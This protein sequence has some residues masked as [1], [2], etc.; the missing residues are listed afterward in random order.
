MAMT[1]Q[2]CRRAPQGD[3]PSAHATRPTSDVRLL[4]RHGSHS[5]IRARCSAARYAGMSAESRGRR[6]HEVA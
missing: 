4:L 2:I 6:R 1:D 5:L 3:R